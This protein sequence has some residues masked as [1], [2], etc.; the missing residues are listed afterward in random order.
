M[1]IK[2]VFKVLLICFSAVKLFKGTISH[3][4]SVGKIDKNK[5]SLCVYLGAVCAKPTHSV[6][7]S[8]SQSKGQQLL[9]HWPN[10]TTSCLR[11]S[12]FIDHSHAHPFMYYL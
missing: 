9:A 4:N 1:F 12:S 6:P 8:F 3:G 11:K 5:A 2:L 10:S 7:I